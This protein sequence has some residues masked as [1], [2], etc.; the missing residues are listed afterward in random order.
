[1][2]DTEPQR[3]EKRKRRWGDAPHEEVSVKIKNR[4][5]VLVEPVIAANDDVL[6]DKKAKA[7]AL[8]ASIKAR[9]AALKSKQNPPATVPK[10]PAEDLSSLP[11]PASKKAK[12]YDLDLTTIGPTFQAVKPEPQKPKVNPYLAHTKDEAEEPLDDR[13]QTAKVR[14]RHKEIKWIEPGTFV[15]IAERKR[16]K[17]VNALQSGFVSGRKKG[18]FVQSNSLAEVYGAGGETV[19]DNDNTLGLRG[20]C[21]NKKMPLVME[22]WDLELLPTKLKKQVTKF[23]SEMQ[24]QHAITQLQQLGDSKEEHEDTIDTRELE[25]QCFDQAALSHSKTAALVQHIVPVKT[26]REYS[27][28]EPTL[29][30]T[31]RELKRQRKLRR[32][33]K[34][35]ELQDMQAAGL[36]APPEP[37]LTL[38][39]FIRVLGDQAFMDPSQMERKVQEQMQARQRAHMQKNEENK[40]TKEQRAEKRTRKMQEDTSQ[41]VSVAIFYVKDMSHP[42]HRTKVDLNALQNNITGGVLQCDKPQVMVCVIA[43]GGPKAIKRFIRLMTVRMKWQGLDEEEEDETPEGEEKAKFNPDNKCELVW[44]G[45][46]T[47]RLFSGF[48]FQS[49]ETSAQCRNALKTKGVGH[50]WDQVSAHACGK[51]DTFTFKLGDT[52]DEAEMQC[53]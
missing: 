23:E 20:D 40:L 16:E 8:Q 45:M 25:S 1:M 4:L 33:E 44:T 3:K 47:K 19:R 42:Y 10:R 11:V 31:K 29:F 49:C 15:E 17:A 36:V 32:S 18:E 48:L 41:A 21:D 26:N 22:W 43:E 30:L 7:L 27:L 37:R 38:R 9:L 52:D 24:L 39:N 53:S 5:P 6:K 14:K 51:G 50:F 35:R 12:V 13:I 2:A 34:Q 28:K 46:A